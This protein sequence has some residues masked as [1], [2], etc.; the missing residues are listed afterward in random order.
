MKSTFWLI[1]LLSIS[2]QLL[3]QNIS[4]SHPLNEESKRSRWDLNKYV[5]SHA[6]LDSI[7]HHKRL[8]N[9]DVIDNWIG[10]GEE[11]SISNDGQYFA[12]T[13]TRGNNYTKKLDTL[14]V[15]STNGSWRE[16]IIGAEP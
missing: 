16:T 3:S 4:S 11:V 6:H 15:Q 8:I 12:Y 10:L 5:W 7:R 13:I 2:C 1:I 9:F 14:I